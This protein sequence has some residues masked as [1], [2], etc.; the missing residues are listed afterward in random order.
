MATARGLGLGLGLR[1][2][3]GGSGRLVDEQVGGLD[4]AVD[5]VHLSVEVHEP[6][7]HRA[8]DRAEDRLGH[9]WLG[10]GLGVG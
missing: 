1:P 6:A 7:E 8:R 2:G 3:L 5:Q 10:L 4:V 9:T